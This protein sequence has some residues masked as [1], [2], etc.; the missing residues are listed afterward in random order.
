MKRLPLLLGVVALAACGGNGG[1]ETVAVTETVHVTTT[2]EAPPPT[3][4][5]GTTTEAPAGTDPDDVA[6]S[7]DIRDF[8]AKRAGSLITITISTYEAWNGSVLTG[9]PLAPGPN[10]LTVLYDVDLDQK[11]DYRAKLIYS[12]GRLSAFISGSGSQFEPIPVRRPNDFTARFTHPVDIFTK[13]PPNG[14]I[15]LRAQSVFAQSVV[16]GEEDRAPDDGQWLGV[17]FNP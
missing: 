11:A 5:E 3:T 2:V 9:D 12:G 8:K 13:L 6:G 16:A 10:T 7:L 1:T 17:P 14:D 15:Q 4:S